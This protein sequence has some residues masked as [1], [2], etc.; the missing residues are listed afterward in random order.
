MGRDGVCTAVFTGSVQ[1]VPGMVAMLGGRLTVRVREHRGR[2]YGAQTGRR[3]ER[4]EGS[5]EG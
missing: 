2:E 5:E 1:G 3:A 4:P